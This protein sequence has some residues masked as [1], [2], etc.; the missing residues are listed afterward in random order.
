VA[1]ALLAGAGL[2]ATWYAS[3]SSWREH[4]APRD[5]AATTPA[6]AAQATARAKPPESPS[7]PRGTAEATALSQAETP[8]P[9]NP[10]PKAAG[11]PAAGELG[12]FKAYY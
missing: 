8:P 2:F 6:M 9:P 3:A 11:R 10:A 4:S 7:P 1:V 5:P 12:E